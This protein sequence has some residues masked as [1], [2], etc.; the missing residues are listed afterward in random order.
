MT[1]FF[2]RLPGT[3]ASLVGSHLILAALLLSVGCLV[4]WTAAFTT[5]LR[6]QQRRD[7]K[8]TADRKLPGSFP[9][10]NR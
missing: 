5:A 7:Q 8:A 2:T 6:R 1:D 3:V 4:L 10:D 9:G